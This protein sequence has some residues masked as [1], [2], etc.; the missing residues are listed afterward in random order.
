MTRGRWRVA[1]AAWR[2]ASND[3]APPEVRELAARVYASEGSARA[4]AVVFLRRVARGLRPLPSDACLVPAL[5]APDR[6]LRAVLCEGRWL[7]ARRAPSL[8]WRN[9]E[10]LAVV[11]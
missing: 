4:L 10:S 6:T 2:C 11:N 8:L 1:I 9:V 3:D 5:F 7:D